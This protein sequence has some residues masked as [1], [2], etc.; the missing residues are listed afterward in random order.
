[1]PETGIARLT[2]EQ[3]KE[4]CERAEQVARKYV[5]SKIPKSKI[6]NL[7]VVVDAEGTKSVTVNVEVNVVLSPLMKNFD[8]DA[9]VDEATK[10]AFDA[11]EGYLGELKCK[12]KNY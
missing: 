10:H 11:I 6:T 12:F 8:V 2:L 7:D 5:M 1:L 4:L 3:V 9:L